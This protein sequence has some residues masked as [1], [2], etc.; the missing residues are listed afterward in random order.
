MILGEFAE[1]AEG[2]EPY[3]YKMKKT[4]DGKCVFLKDSS[5]SIYAKR[6]LVCRFYPFELKN[7]GNNRYTFICTEECPAI[8]KGP[9][10]RRS[11]FERLFKNLTRLAMKNKN[12]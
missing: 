9:L 6:P 3:I 12:E 7:M 5:C 2:F 8:G 4:L 10:L 1:K 11:Y